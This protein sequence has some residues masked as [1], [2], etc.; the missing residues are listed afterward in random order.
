M[1]GEC[2]SVAFKRDRR[3]YGILRTDSADLVQMQV[4]NRLDTFTQG[5]IVI[6][7]VEK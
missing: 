1:I 6:D 5:P 2:R 4:D 3:H 7:R